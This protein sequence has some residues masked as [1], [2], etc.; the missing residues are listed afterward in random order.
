M[1]EKS[2]EKILECTACPSCKGNISKRDEQTIECEN[3]HE[4]FDIING[5]PHLLNAKSKDDLN[6]F[7]GT[8]SHPADN[9]KETK[10][11][12]LLQRIWRSIPEPITPMLSVSLRIKAIYKTWILSNRQNKNPDILV[13]GTFM[14]ARR[15]KTELFLETE[16]A[17]EA[18][19]RLDVSEKDGTDIIADG[20]RMPFPDNSFDIVVAQATMKHLMNPYSFV[21]EVHRV[22]KPGGHFYCEVAYLLA[23]HRW[24]GDYVRFTPPGIE[25]LLKQFSVIELGF[26][27]GP[28]YTVVEILTIFLASLFSFNKVSLYS[29]FSKLF[30]W[31]LLPVKYLDPL[32]INNKWADYLGQVNYCISRKDD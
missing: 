25:N 3:C 30:S 14:P 24:P 7:W 21:D 4:S 16:K 11:Q 9:K 8:G 22:L 28:S 13:V 31:L 27:R 17:Y 23:F 15:K 5:I 32:F 19:L 10:K 29:G 6:Q 18:A 1:R 2:L 26:T 12:S 20:H